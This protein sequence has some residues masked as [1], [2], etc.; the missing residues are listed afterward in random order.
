MDKSKKNPFDIDEQKENVKNLKKE[1]QFAIKWAIKIN[2]YI[3][4]ILAC[5]KVL[6]FL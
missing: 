5:L 3:L 2:F 4:I 6:I 1:I